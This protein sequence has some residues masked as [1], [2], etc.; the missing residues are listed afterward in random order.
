MET[1]GW[2]KAEQKQSVRCWQD[3][4]LHHP[5]RLEQRPETLVLNGHPEPVNLPQRSCE[6]ALEGDVCFGRNLVPHSF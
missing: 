5:P 3:Q 1:K 6:K 2:D 4:D